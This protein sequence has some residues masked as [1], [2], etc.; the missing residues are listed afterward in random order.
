MQLIF[1]LRRY[2]L[3]PAHGMKLS[4]VQRCD[5]CS[6]YSYLVNIR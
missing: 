5:T 4:I 6:V 3:T 1:A 2:N